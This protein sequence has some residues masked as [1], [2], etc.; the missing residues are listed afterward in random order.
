MP[1]A[2]RPTPWAVTVQ[3]RAPS[4]PLEALATLLDALAG[5]A[6]AGSFA[7]DGVAVRLTVSAAGVEAATREGLARLRDASAGTVLADA[8]AV[9]L[10]AVEESTEPSR[11]ALAL[12]GLELAGVEEVAELFE[13]SPTQVRDLMASPRFP[14]PIAQ[15]AQGPV[16]LRSHLER[17]R[18]RLQALSS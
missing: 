12:D 17:Y 6:P 11:F 2:D 18:E 3:L 7:G 10:S 16:W 8:P 9:G 5:H 14:E 13:L 15:L 4:A 1:S